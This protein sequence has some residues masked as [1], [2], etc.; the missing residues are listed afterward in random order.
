MLTD[1]SCLHNAGAAVP[2]LISKY[3]LKRTQYRPTLVRNFA[4]YWLIFKIH[5]LAE[6]VIKFAC[7]NDYVTDSLTWI[8]YAS[9]GPP[10]KLR[11]RRL[12]GWQFRLARRR[13]EFFFGGGGASRFRLAAAAGFGGWG[14]YLGMDHTA[15][16]LYSHHTRLSH[17]KY[18]QDGGTMASVSNLP[19]NLHL[20]SSEQWCWSGERGILTELSLC[21]S[22]V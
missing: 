18:S 20:A 17:R 22:I 6:S 11:W 8:F 13:A 15:F 19:P 4:K 2:C 1:L 16:T 7:F 12:S 9:R 21:Y 5:S 14:V 10:K 3:R